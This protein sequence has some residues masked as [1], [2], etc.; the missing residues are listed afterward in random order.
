MGVFYPF[1]GRSPCSGFC[2]VWPQCWNCVSLRR[3]C[4]QPIWQISSEGIWHT[5]AKKFDFLR[6]SLAHVVT[7]VSGSQ[8]SL[9]KGREQGGRLRK[10]GRI[11]NWGSS[12]LGSLE[13]LRGPMEIKYLRSV[14]I[15]I[16][17]SFMLHGVAATFLASQVMFSF[18]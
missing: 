7:V 18:C 17:R 6:P 8:E 5:T 15:Q 10:R 12:L 11:G 13:S 2:M 3:A 4:V 14:G 16:E 9:G 1:I